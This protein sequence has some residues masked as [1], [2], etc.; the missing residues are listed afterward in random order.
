MD[1]QNALRGEA[2]EPVPVGVPDSRNR[3]DAAQRC[4]RQPSHEQHGLRLPGVEFERRGSGVE[5]QGERGDTLQLSQREQSDGG[6]D[7][8]GQATAPVAHH[9]EG[10]GIHSGSNG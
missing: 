5:R 10:L 2:L 9:G 4:R 1:L 8:A 3:G 7:H 6:R